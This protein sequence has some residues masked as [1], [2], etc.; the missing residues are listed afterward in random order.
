MKKFTFLKM[1]LLVAFFTLF[2]FG[3]TAQTNLVQNPSFESGLTNWTAGPTANYTSPTLVTTDAQQ[4]TN[5][6]QYIA[7]ATT[8]FYQEI[9]VTAGSTYTVSFYY[10]ATGDGTDGRIWSVFKDTSGGLIYLAGTSSAAANDPLRNNNGYLASATDWTQH[11]VT[12]T[13]PANAVTFQLAVRAYTGGTVSFDNFSLVESAT[14][15]PTITASP[16][17]VS[18]TAE[19]GATSPTQDITVGGTNLTGDITAIL[20]GTDASQFT[21]NPTTIPQSGGSA[22][23][24]ITVTYIPSAAAA[25]HS[26]V[27]TLTSAGAS[28]VVIN[29]NAE[30]TEPASSAGILTFD[31]G[32]LAGD[33]LTAPSNTNDPNL[34][35]STISRGSGLIA[36]GNG[37][38]FN[39]TNWSTISIAD[40]VANDQYMEFTITP[41]AGYGFDVSSIQFQIQRSNTGP[42]AVALRNSLDNYTANLDTE[43]AILDN[44]SIQT[45]N[46]I[47]SQVM[48]S[49][50]VTYRIYM[51]AEAAGGSGGFEGTGNDIIVNGSVSFSTGIFNNSMD[52]AYAWTSHGKVMLQATAGEMIEIFNIAGQK[53][54]TRVADDGL[55]SVSVPV[56]GVVI[57]KAGNRVSK[58]IL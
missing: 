20:S 44:T 6:V 32:G 41:N 10:K 19:V 17:T 33:E 11:S 27:V 15:T 7:T 26:A 50:P 28:P 48:S 52:D 3:I 37:D 40:A 25:T 58:V 34:S 49:S 56:K 35:P 45:F 18:L 5:S 23:G 36:S 39:A 31:F 54:V 55:N 14:T 47:F 53:V 24:A 22:S 4:G 2:G 8:G 16:S 30:T 9:A 1:M 57:V 12:F 21:V 43:Y 51:Y 13:V 46:F 42:V 38:R 29:L